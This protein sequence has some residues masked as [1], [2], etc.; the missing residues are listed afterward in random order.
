LSFDIFFV[1]REKALK[2]PPKDAAEA[3]GR[4]AAAH[5]GGFGKTFAVKFADESWL[6]FNCDNDGGLL[7]MR[8]W[9]EQRAAVIFDILKESGWIAVSPQ[10]PVTMLSHDDASGIA[11]AIFSK[12]AHRRIVVRSRSELFEAL[13]AS[14][15]EWAGYR[16]QVVKG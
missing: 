8:R 3:L 16:D 14:F 7:P 15:G 1:S 4:A 5:G 10:E 13:D 12:T 11:E 6:E 2:Q 9:D